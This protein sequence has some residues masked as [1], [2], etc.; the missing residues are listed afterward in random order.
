MKLGWLYLFWSGMDSLYLIRLLYINFSE[1]RIPIYSDFQSFVLLSSEHGIYSVVFFLL[2]MVLNV[3]IIFSM[4]L[5]FC[6]S[7][8]AP[9][10]AYLQIP[11]R[12]L[13]AIPSLSF[14]VWMS[15]V[16]GVTSSVFFIVLLLSSE[17]I[18]FIS[19]FFR[20]KFFVA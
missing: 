15:K 14:L 6:G 3:S 2:G 4:V 17:L 8:K 10:L 13:L 16:V 12:L 9:Y 11:L 20:E 7:Q 19:I 18:K 1:G 5:F